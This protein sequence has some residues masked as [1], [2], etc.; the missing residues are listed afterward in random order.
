[1]SLY[2][3]GKV[4]PQ[5]SSNAD[6][7]FQRHT[8]VFSREVGPDDKAVLDEQS[9]LSPTGIYFSIRRLTKRGSCNRLVE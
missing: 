4:I 6:R 3:F 5:L 7:F 8:E 2:R 1:M 9:E